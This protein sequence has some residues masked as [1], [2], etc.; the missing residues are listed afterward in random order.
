VTFLAEFGWTQAAVI[1][2]GIGIF[3]AALVALFKD[4]FWHWRHA[5]G[6]EVGIE[7]EGEFAVALRL[8]NPSQ[9]TAAQGVAVR[10]I[11]YEGDPVERALR[12]RWFTEVIHSV[13]RLLPRASGETSFGIAP[14]GEVRLPLAILKDADTAEDKAVALLPAALGQGEGAL[15]VLVA[16]PLAE[17]REAVEQWPEAGEVSDK[18]AMIRLEVAADNVPARLY[19]VTISRPHD[20]PPRDGMP[21][22]P[23]FRAM[24]F[25]VGLVE[26][27][28]H[29]L[30][31]AAGEHERNAW[32]L[33]VPPET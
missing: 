17:R 29:T 21:L 15:E 18:P 11:D 7:R 14:N 27:A 6:L 26:G 13:D 31:L 28:Q 5:P 4:E 12:P 1:V 33:E 24:T 16:H 23:A 20:V 3:V 32:L 19:T 8:R 9:R 22:N 2:S 30:V 10:V 25:D